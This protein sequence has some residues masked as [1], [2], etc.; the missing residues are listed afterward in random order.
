MVQEAFLARDTRTASNPG[1]ERGPVE[2]PDPAE[3]LHAEN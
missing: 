3:P 2:A 1:S